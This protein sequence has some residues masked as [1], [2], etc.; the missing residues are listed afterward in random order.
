MGELVEPREIA[1]ALDFQAR[2]IPGASK[3]THELT[4]SAYVAWWRRFRRRSD[5]PALFS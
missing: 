2:F 3:Q 1:L 4:D 5:D